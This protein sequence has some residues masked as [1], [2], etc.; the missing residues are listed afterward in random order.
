MVPPRAAA[1]RWR[2]SC[3]TSYDWSETSLIVELFTRERGRV[4]VAAKGAKRPY[5]QLRPVL[6]PF[7]RLWVQLGRTPADDRPRCTCCAAPSGPA[8]RRCPPAPRCSPASTSTSC[9]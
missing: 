5:S 8:A 7:Q 4:V 6:L 9:C 1:A 2:P 3:C